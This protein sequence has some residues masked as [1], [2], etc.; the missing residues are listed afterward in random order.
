MRWAREKRKEEK[1]E[2]ERRRTDR[3]EGRIEKMEGNSGNE[4]K[5]D[6]E[7]VN[8]EGMWEG[9]SPDGIDNDNTACWEISDA[10]ARGKKSRGLKSCLQP[11]S[12]PVCLSLLQASWPQ[13][14]NTRASPS[15]RVEM[16]S[17]SL[18]NRYHSRISFHSFRSPKK[19]RGGDIHIRGN[20][21]IIPL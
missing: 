4:I 13:G 7:R 10:P 3:Y 1:K 14:A 12:R 16:L 21:I 18:R 19:R 15:R 17:I 6:C 20:P 2:R 11:A 5:V 9:G 8:L